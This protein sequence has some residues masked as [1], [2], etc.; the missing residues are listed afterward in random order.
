MTLSG[1]KLTVLGIIILGGLF[2]A[3]PLT[4]LI[5][6]GLIIWVAVK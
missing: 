3:I 1:T 6:L 2:L 4:P 5:V